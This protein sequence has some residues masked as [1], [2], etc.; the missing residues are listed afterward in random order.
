LSFA[1]LD[2]AGPLPEVI[3]EM[4]QLLNRM[5]F[6]VKLGLMTGSAVVGLSLFAAIAYCTMRFV[7]I[8]SPTYLDIALAYQLAGDCYDPPA[9]LVG[10][11]APAIAAEDATTPEATTKYVE[12]LRGTSK[13]FEASH[14]HYQE[15]LPAGAMRDLMRDESYPSGHQWF[16]IAEQE[17]IP[18]LLAGNHEAAR[19]IRIEKMDALF[20]RHKAANDQLAELTGNWIPSQETN[21]AH[22]LASRS[23]ALGLIFLCIVGIVGFLGFSISRGIVHPVRKTLDVLTAMSNGDLSQSLEVGSSDEMG[24]VA[25]ALNQ[26]IGSF[27]EVLSSILAAASQA[28][29]ASAELMATAQE[30]SS[31]SR[32]QAHEA[33]RVSSSM[34]SMAVAIQEVSR[35][36]V[37]AA[38]AGQAT[39]DAANRGTQVV[40]ETRIV[41]QRSAQ[42][43][44]EASAQIALL[45]NSSS[46]IGQVINVIEE[47]ANQTNLLAL[48]AAIEAARAGEQGRGFAVVAGEV[49]RLAERTTDATKT[50][51]GMIVSIQSDSAS[52]VDMME[53]RKAQVAALMK[54]VEECSLA[55]SEIVHMARNEET[56]VRQIATASEQQAD[57]STQ[58]AESMKLIS[59]FS[60]YAHTAGEQ[61]VRACSD[62]SKLASDLERNA[63]GFKLAGI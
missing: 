52:A 1:R 12:L 7:C 62:L 5:R 63:Q 10:A 36:A 43:T 31:H 47:I 45:G 15:V 55:L 38:H 19:K 46:Q 13:A 61:T 42:M 57:A 25:D 32:E 48:N 8:G 4:M 33:E 11:L 22:I 41:L 34:A 23:I 60:A 2:G 37:D 16:Q 29:A 54:K 58:V 53:G 40:E 6:S 20:A 39:E 51:A 59:N 9:S 26:T 28:A 27:H 17:Y 3:G 56:M 44:T 49:R 50:I 35:A 14:K 18:A 30:T 24:M 21:A